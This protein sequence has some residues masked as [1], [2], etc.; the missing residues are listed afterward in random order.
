[1]NHR[2][3]SRERDPLR[4]KRRIN[5]PI[6]SIQEITK[7][8]QRNQRSSCLKV[9]EWSAP[10]DQEILRARREILSA[11]I[12]K[13]DPVLYPPVYRNFSI[14]KKSYEAMEKILKVY[15]YKEG[16]KPIFHEPLLWGI[17]AAEGWFMKHMEENE[18]FLVDDPAK[19]H[20]F[21]MPYSSTILRFKL[22]DPVVRDKGIMVD[23]LKHYVAAISAKYPFWNRTG[24][25]DHFSVACHDWASI[26]K[27]KAMGDSI[28]AICNAE[29]NGAFELG[30]DVSITLTPVRHPRNPLQN[31]G[32]MPGRKRDTLA[33]FAGQMH[34]QVRP[35][36]FQHWGENR[37]PDVQVFQRLPRGGGRTYDEHM[38]RSRFC[39]C[40]SGYEVNSPRLAETFFYEC[41]PV[42]ISDNFVPPFFEVLNW[43][44]FSVVVPV[45]DIP[46]LKEILQSIP[47]RKFLALQ[48]GVKKVQRHFLWHLKPKRY[49][50][51][52]MTLHSI[53]FNRV[54]QFRS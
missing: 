26:F 38:K 17:Y 39:L 3:C 34:G 50:L 53:W 18:R 8:L 35:L 7:M 46:K 16:E 13:A 11:L 21:Y 22:F 54:L 49:D 48:K 47:R 27:V 28:M 44:A 6:R 31:V 10:V 4:I 51:F 36:L 19:A 29:M 24:G 2:N 41:V 42:I 14:F 43:E 30:K 33:F 1:M 20:L 5:A 37:D 45:K 52:Y 32:G 12:V 25:A 23:Q 9:P 40:P 15:V